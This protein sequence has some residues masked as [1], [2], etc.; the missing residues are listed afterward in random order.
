MIRVKTRIMFQRTR[1]TEVYAVE[2]RIGSSS[3]RQN[4]I[5]LGILTFETYIKLPILIRII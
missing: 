5:N 4:E 3:L 2:Y 1:L